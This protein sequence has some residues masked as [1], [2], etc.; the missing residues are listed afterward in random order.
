M[1]GVQSR[2]EAESEKSE[3]IKDE[4]SSQVSLSEFI[5]LS[6]SIGRFFMVASPNPNSSA[7]SD[8]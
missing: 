7:L 1:W 2:F 5:S 3:N 8:Y 4:G 6:S